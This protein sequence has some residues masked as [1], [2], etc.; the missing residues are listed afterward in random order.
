MAHGGFGPP[1]SV[2]TTTAEIAERIRDA[3]AHGTRLRVIGRGHWLAANRPVQADAT[4]PLD[5][6]SG[7]VDYVPGDFTLTARAGTTLAE[8]ARAARDQ[9]QWL[10]LDPLGSDEGSIGA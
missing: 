5:G 2:T 1:G 8:I 6:Y 9:G 10:A 3:A 4:L 7:I